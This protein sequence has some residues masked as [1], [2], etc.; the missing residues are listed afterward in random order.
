MNG[1]KEKITLSGEIDL[2]K[3][4]LSSELSLIQALRN[5]HFPTK[6]IAIENIMPGGQHPARQRLVKE[7]MIA[8]QL[9]MA[10]LKDRQAH[11]KAPPLEK[12]E[13]WYKS[14]LNNFPHA[15]TGA[16]EKD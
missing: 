15:L 11:L 16:Q 10:S 2:Q 3:Y 1:K 9:G 8:F 14:V 12:Q 4:G 7:E 6:D 5:I 13:D